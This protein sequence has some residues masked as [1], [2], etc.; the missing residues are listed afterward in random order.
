MLHENNLGHAPFRDCSQLKMVFYIVYVLG[1]FI[2]LIKESINT[3]L[4][5]TN[6]PSTLK[7]INHAHSK[8]VL[9]RD[10][11]SQLLLTINLIKLRNCR[12]IS[13][14]KDNANKRVDLQKRFACDP[15]DG[16]F[17]FWYRGGGVSSLLIHSIHN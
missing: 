10:L 11:N 9:F 4:V 6:S 5:L 7:K 15:I 14:E 12:W 8:Q 13:G 1:D 3:I 2:M 17:W 16:W